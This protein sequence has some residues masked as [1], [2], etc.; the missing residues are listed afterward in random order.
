MI[1]YVNMM[2]HLN[3]V[4]LS[5]NIEKPNYILINYKIQIFAQTVI[6]PIKRNN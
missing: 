1:L 3:L 4:N 2:K 5:I 6:N